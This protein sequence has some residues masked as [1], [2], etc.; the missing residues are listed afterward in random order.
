M[1]QETSKKGHLD[2]KDLVE[3]I[4]NLKQE[5]SRLKHTVAEQALDITTLKQWNEFIKK[6]LRQDE[7]NL[8]ESSLKKNKSSAPK[9]DSVS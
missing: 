2:P 5:N 8:Q 3:E 6:K 1:K 4:E 7:L 9:K